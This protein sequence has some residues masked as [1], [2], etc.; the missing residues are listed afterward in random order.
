MVDVAGI[1]SSLFPDVTI[2]EHVDVEGDY[3]R[4]EFTV[5]A[6]LD[7]DSVRFGA[8]PPG[9]P[10]D[11]RERGDRS[12]LVVD[13][14]KAEDASWREAKPALRGAWR[15]AGEASLESAYPFVSSVRR[16]LDDG[17]VDDVCD[18]FRPK[19]P[20]RFYKM[21]ENALYLNQ[22]VA[23]Q[24]VS[25]REVRRRKSQIADRYGDEAYAVASLCSAGYFDEGRF[26]RELYRS[27]EGD[28]SDVEY[29]DLFTTLVSNKPFVVFVKTEDTPQEVYDAVLMKVLRGTEYDVEVDFVDVRGINRTNHRTIEEAVARLADDYGDLSYDRRT[30]GR[31]LV[32]RI[33][34]TSF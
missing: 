30:D 9:T 3:D 7:V 8:L 23:D 6:G 21:V 26:F 4:T 19:I 24:D 28:G 33:D 22:A 11:F 13:P 27:M 12:E 16:S 5:A 14:E 17:Y 20:F 10:V 2:G 29:G 25:R 1:L 15:E 18:F 34:A 32:V 31:E